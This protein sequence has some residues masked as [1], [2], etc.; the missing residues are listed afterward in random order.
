LLLDSRSSIT[1][2]V[3]ITY[4]YDP[5]Y[6]LT[7]AEYDNGMAYLYEYDAVGNRTQ[8]DHCLEGFG[9]NTTTYT[10][11]IA[12]RLASVDDGTGVITFQWDA[13]IRIIFSEP[14]R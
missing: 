11:D 7:G 2:T 10:Y 14:K 8:F 3:I 13:R 1:N 9:C 4:T 6:R 5:L 12:N